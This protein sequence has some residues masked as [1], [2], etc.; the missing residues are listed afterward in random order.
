M[1]IQSFDDFN[2]AVIAA[3]RDA[4]SNGFAMYAIRW[5]LGHSTVEVRKPSLRSAQMRVLCCDGHREPTLA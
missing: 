5:P 4:R 2:E 1:S 3:Q